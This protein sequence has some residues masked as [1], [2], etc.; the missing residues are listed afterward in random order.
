MNQLPQTEPPDQLDGMKTIRGHY[1]SRKRFLYSAVQTQEHTH[2]S[3]ES[4]IV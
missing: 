1:Q 2:S 3:Q 4:A